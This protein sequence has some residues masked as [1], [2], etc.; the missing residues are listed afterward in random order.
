[1]PTNLHGLLDWMIAGMVFAL[2]FSVWLGVVLVW[3]GRRR[4]RQER[5][6]ERFRI[7]AAPL[8]SESEHHILR[9]WHEGHEV[10]TTAEG[11]YRPTLISRLDRARQNAGWHLRAPMLL[12]LLAGIIVG[13]AALAFVLT[14][15]L[16]SSI[17][18]VV[19]VVVAANLYL[20]HC[21]DRREALFEAR[22]LDALQIAVRSLRAGHPLIGAFHFIA[23]EGGPPVNEL[24]EEVCQQQSL[25]M[26]LEDALRKV[27][28]RY[29]SPDLRLFVSSVVVQLRGGGPLADMMERLADVI[30]DRMRVTRRARV[31][32]AQTQFSK[33]VLL[34]LPVV[35]FAV[36]AV[37]NPH[38]LEPLFAS[39]LGRV[40]LA[41]AGINLVLGTWVMNRL[42]VI[43]F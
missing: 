5:L 21:I 22:F 16:L 1:M 15:S 32:T 7:V 20:H 10:T 12:V 6:E 37:V 41:V 26:S 40:L 28:D 3:A 17:A 4:Q 36:L 25:G 27:T 42:A 19:A 29:P 23:E 24:F 18:V 39:D 2:V 35:L 33:R 8:R 13:A 34:G 38:Y 14:G 30:R 11:R 31:L 9:L 43:R